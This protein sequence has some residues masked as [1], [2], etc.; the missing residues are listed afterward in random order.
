MV[1]P[2]RVLAIDVSG[3]G[4]GAALLGP[5]GIDVERVPPAVRRG[6]DLVPA[7]AR[8]LAA[9]GLEPKDLDLVACGVG[10]GSFTG[11]RIGIATAA[12]LAYAARLPVLD[13]G[14]LDGIAENAPATAE[15]VVVLLDARQGRVFRGRFRREGEI[16]VAEGAYDA[17]TAEE[18]LAAIPKGAFVLGDARGMGAAEAP[19]RPDVIARIAAARFAAGERKRPEELRPLYL[20]LSDPEIRR[21]GTMHAPPHAP[22][23]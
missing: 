12:A 6:R 15:R 19:V 14:S 18:A 5:F 21:S 23:S 8:L 13:V 4:G 10:P 7:I 3:P 17:P 1:S 9:R 20:R 22:L 11:I 2:P 16:L